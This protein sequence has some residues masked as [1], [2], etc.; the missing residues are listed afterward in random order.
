MKKKRTCPF[1]YAAKLLL[2]RGEKPERCQSKPPSLSFAQL[3]PSVPLVEET[4]HVDQC[5]VLPVL[6][7]FH[8]RFEGHQKYFDCILKSGN[9]CFTFG[10]VLN[11]KPFTHRTYALWT[12]VSN[13]Y[14]QIHDDS[15]EAEEPFRF[16]SVGEVPIISSPGPLRHSAV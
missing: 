9:V 3:S 1:F 4:L 5:L 13:P 11:S 6:K 8:S 2:L 15:K 16:S 7:R 10:L 12:V 14:K